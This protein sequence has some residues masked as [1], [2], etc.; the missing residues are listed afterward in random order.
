ME[1]CDVCNISSSSYG[2]GIKSIFSKI[3]FRECSLTNSIA[4]GEGG[5]FHLRDS[6]LILSAVKTMKNKPAEIYFF[7]I[8]IYKYKKVK[9]FRF[10][11]LK[12]WGFYLFE[13]GNA[14]NKS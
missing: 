14:N 10:I 5:L 6:E 9:F 13:I 4:F 2:A 8:L 11:C 12:L 1:I 7:G 3:P